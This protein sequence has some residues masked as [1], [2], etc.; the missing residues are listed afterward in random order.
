MDTNSSS[1]KDEGEDENSGQW[2]LRPSALWTVADADGETGD[3]AAVGANNF[4]TEHG[5]RSLLTSLYNQ[6]NDQA[7]NVNILP[8]DETTVKLRTLNW[9]INMARYNSTFLNCHETAKN[10]ANEIL[11]TGELDVIVLNEYPPNLHEVCSKDLHAIGGLSTFQLAPIDYGTAIASRYRP[12]QTHSIPLSPWRTGEIF[13]IQCLQNEKHNDESRVVNEYVWVVGTHL[14][15]ARGRQRLRE[16]RTLLKELKVIFKNAGTRLEKERVI[17]LGDF[18]QPREKDYSCEEWTMISEGLL[19]RGER[20]DD[21]VSSL[22]EAHGFRCV[23]D[24]INSEHPQ[25]VKTNWQTHHPPAT[26]WSGTII[27][28]AYYHGDI[29][30]ESVSIGPG[31]GFSDH[32]MVVVDWKW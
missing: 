23:Y 14:D 26:H 22:L 13:Q 27:D 24:A 3:T 31:G 2:K 10:I 20:L 19:Y 6:D 18:N 7:S 29:Q 17:I 30:P 1:S 15:H 25:G 9:N 11:E 8:K 12:E 16:M 28:F 4:Y 5:S 32:R 21:G